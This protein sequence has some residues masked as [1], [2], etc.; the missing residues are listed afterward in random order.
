MAGIVVKRDVRRTAGNSGCGIV[1][2]FDG[3]ITGGDVISGVGG[4]HDFAT[5]AYLSVILLPSIA[6]NGNISCIVPMVSHVDIPEHGVDVIVTEQGVADIR[7]LTPKERAERIIDRCAHPAYQPLLK[8][9]FVRAKK[10]GGGHQ[11][12][13]IEESFSFHQRLLKTGSMREE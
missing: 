9:Y 8:D 7:G 2:H 12:H 3:G 5:N 10:R 6:K 11:P 4:A 1:F 13:L